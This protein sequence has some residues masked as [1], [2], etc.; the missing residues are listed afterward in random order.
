M[1]RAR[2]FEDIYARNAWNG[3]S[4]RS[5]PGS[6]LGATA[7]LRRVLPELVAGVRAMSVLDA[8]CGEG[9]WMPELPGY[10]GVD[11]APSA[12]AEAR[13]RHP[14]R[15]FEVADICADPLP[16]VDL[17]FSRDGLQ[18]LPIPDGLAALENFRRTGATWLVC[19]T[20]EGGRTSAR[21][22]VGGYHEPD[23][24]KPP[25]SLGRPWMVIEDGAWVDRYPYPHKFV[26]VWTL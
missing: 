13:R 1:S 16:T 18:H 6:E 9:G 25:F 5:G 14:D 8:P 20:F 19:S 23:M 26:G 4:T 12:I 22:R 15:R 7:L 10:V 21:V 3:A 24:E 11:V 2:V 17:V